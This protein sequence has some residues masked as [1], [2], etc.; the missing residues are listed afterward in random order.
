M[1]SSDTVVN[2]IGQPVW[3]E[4][5]FRLLAGRGTLADDIA[6]P[7]MADAAIVRSRYAHARIP[8]LDK[9]SSAC[10]AGR[11]YAADGLGGDSARCGTHGAA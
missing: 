10:I 8:S 1:K 7:G 4:E 2:G 5:D 9:G 6:L 11:D 3:H